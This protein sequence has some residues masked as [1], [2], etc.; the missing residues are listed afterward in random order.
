MNNKEALK[1]DGYFILKN[2][3]TAKDIAEY[4]KHLEDLSG[5]KPD[6]FI[7]QHPIKAFFKR[8]KSKKGVW[9]QP[10]GV[11]K[12]K[13]FWPLLWNDKVVSAIKKALG[14]D[15]HIL[16]HNDLHVGFSASGWH[17]DSVDRQFGEGKEWDES[18]EP[19]KLVRVGVYLQSYEESKFSLGVLPGTHK[20]ESKWTIFERFTPLKL[21]IFGRMLVALRYLLMGQNLLTHKAFWFKP[22]PGDAI[23]FDPRLLHNGKYPRGPKYSFFIG[24]GVPNSFYDYHENYYEN[25]RKELKYQPFDEE[26]KKLL[27]QKGLL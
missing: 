18:K 22:T 5:I 2:A 4:R 26:L 3:I 7:D 27:K 19:Y 12:N 21:G 9:A 13:V 17:R 8:K 23:I 10:E 24:Y 14:D 11:S 16:H 25:V 6:G 15:V 20:Y 1:K